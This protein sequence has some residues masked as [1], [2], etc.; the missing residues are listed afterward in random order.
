M[1]ED[2]YQYKLKA[3]FCTQSKEIYL[4]YLLSGKCLAFHALLKQKIHLLQ[5]IYL[6]FHNMLSRL[7]YYYYYKELE[8]KC[9]NEERL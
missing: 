8:K 7:T 6:Y 4:Q 3:I 1:A 9:I 2:N 5:G